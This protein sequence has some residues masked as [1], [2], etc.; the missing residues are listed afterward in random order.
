MQYGEEVVV[1]GR[2]RGGTGIFAFDGRIVGKL[3][4]I[5]NKYTQMSVKTLDFSEYVV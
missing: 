4:F 1:Q 3:P 2:F 5:H